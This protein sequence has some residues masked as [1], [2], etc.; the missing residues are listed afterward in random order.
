MARYKFEDNIFKLSETKDITQLPDEWEFIIRDES[1][2]GHCICNRK[3]K[4]V[5]YFYNYKTYKYIMVGDSCKDKLCLKIVKEGGVKRYL[6]RLINNKGEYLEILNMLQYSYDTMIKIYE[7][8]EDMANTNDIKIINKIIGILNDILLKITNNRDNIE[9]LM[10]NLTIKVN[11]INKKEEENKILL[12][13]IR[14]EE[15]ELEKI[16]NEEEELKRNKILN[17]KKPDEYYEK[18]RIRNE[19][20]KIGRERREKEILENMLKEEI[21]NKNQT[22]VIDKV[23]EKYEID[24]NII[25]I[26][27]EENK[28]N[29]CNKCKSTWCVICFCENPNFHEE[30]NGNQFCIKCF[31]WKNRKC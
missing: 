7:Y 18:I 24:K 14:N 12:E 31:K 2:E 8:F 3:I 28:K 25:R 1:D 27:S 5:N 10:N 29:L 26:S 16:R 21:I 9:K 19:N 15:E 23:K 22:N 6:N 17:F 20:L 11:E 13:R 30:E 4:Y